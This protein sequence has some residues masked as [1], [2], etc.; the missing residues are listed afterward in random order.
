MRQGLPFWAAIGTPNYILQWIAFG[1]P[2]FWGGVLP[3]HYEVINDMKDG[4]WVNSEQGII[5]HVEALAALG[6]Y[7]PVLF[8]Y[9]KCVLPLFLRYSSNKMRC[10]QDCRGVNLHVIDFK[11]SLKTSENFCEL[12]SPGSIIITSD[13][14]KCWH[15]LR[16]L[17]KDSLYYCLR[18]IK[19]NTP[20][21]FRPTAKTLGRIMSHLQ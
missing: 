7:E 6:C 17:P 21:Y 5:K 18:I 10:I 11:F 15:Q 14:S 1:I 16:H 20:Y 8:K 9:V 12:L 2:V 3:H 19:H 4:K 13:F